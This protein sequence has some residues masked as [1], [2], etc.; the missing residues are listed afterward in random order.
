MA[1]QPTQEGQ[2]TPTEETPRV[3]LY[4]IAGI[5]TRDTIVIPIF[6]NGQR[7]EALVD[8]GSS[9]TFVDTTVARRI[10]V[11]SEPANLRA[12]VA[13]GDKVPCAAVARG[14]TM[15]VGREESPIT[16]ASA[17]AVSTWC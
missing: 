9:H 2:A 3:L 5:R 4:A 7:L 14:I 16:D 10:T 13:N 6:I 8:T 11:E 12:T 15:F 17:S 1:E